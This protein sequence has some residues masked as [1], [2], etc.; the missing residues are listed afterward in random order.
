MVLR[1]LLEGID[2]VAV[3]GSLEVDVTG[4]YYDSRE[5]TEGGLFIAVKGEHLDGADFTGDALER[6]AS[7]VLSG[8]P[9]PA[10]ALEG[11]AT[12]VTVSDPRAA[13]APLAANFYGR[14]S[15]HLT[16]VGVTGTNGKT[17]AGFLIK[18]IL[19]AAGL[20]AG[21]IGTISYYIKD[22][23]YP[24]PRTTPEAVD[25]QR[26]LAEMLRAG[27]THA[28]AEVSSHALS[29]GRVD[30]TQFDVAVFTNL[31]REHLDFHHGMD[32]YFAAKQK[33]F[34]N[35]LSPKGAAVINVDDT[36]GRALSKLLA[37][38]SMAPRLVGFGLDEGAG[39]R[40][41]DIESTF[42]GLQFSIIEDGVP[43]RVSS[44]MAGMPNVYNILS[45]AAAARAM[46]VGWQSI[47]A[48]VLALRNVSGRFERISAGQDFMLVVDYAHTPD[49]LESLLKTARGMAEESGGRVVTV[50]GCGGERDRGKRPL[51][52][53]A[54]AALSDL[55]V[56][57]SD[58]PRA[59]D[60]VRI[61]DDI[62]AGVKSGAGVGGHTAEIRVV[63]DRKEAIIQAVAL[64]KA[65]DAVIIA[66]KGHEDYQEINGVRHPFSDREAALRAVRERTKGEG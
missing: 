53:A 64:A 21:L 29:F 18:S 56:V 2:A 27:L 45:A 57:T 12:F 4:L 44:P 62:M 48:G 32:E 22:K 39:I 61:I 3:G 17:T 28:V 33:L 8:G 25:F 55:V 34:T 59:E 9:P 7:A 63:P 40:A 50:F 10:D 30:A 31:T 14:P 66:G 42:D 24:A 13:M 36:Y 23:Q 11:G 38:K 49:A 60:P 51:M 5:V 58:N 43:H 65:G 20:G 47:R 6:G 15:E 54:A 52:G 46:G 19:E 1:E 35:L 41:V 37:E 26:L 16:T